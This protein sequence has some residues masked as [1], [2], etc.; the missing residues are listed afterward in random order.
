MLGIKDMEIMDIFL[1]EKF[2]MYWGETG[3]VNSSNIDQQSG[4]VTELMNIASGHLIK[5]MDHG[6]LPGE[7]ANRN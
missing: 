4:D 7:L 1:L 6:W 2:T 5:P 3:G